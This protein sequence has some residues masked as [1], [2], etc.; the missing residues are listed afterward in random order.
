M[1]LK[2]VTNLI[3]FLFVNFVYAQNF[4]YRSN[5][6][7]GGE[8][9]TEK[10]DTLFYT[11]DSDLEFIQKNLTHFQPSYFNHVTLKRKS[12]RPIVRSLFNGY[13]VEFYDSKNRLIKYSYFEN[14]GSSFNVEIKYF[15]SGKPYLLIDYSLDEHHSEN[16]VFS[17]QYSIKY[18]DD[19]EL[20]EIE[21]ID[22]FG[23]QC[24]FKR[25]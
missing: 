6:F 11:I 15:E 10:V 22:G 5:C 21:S 25:L 19:Q 14:T 4:I 1:K 3:L 20:I 2:I 16:G 23:F 24:K 7:I 12:K 17:I 8:I 9:H 13:L 18:N